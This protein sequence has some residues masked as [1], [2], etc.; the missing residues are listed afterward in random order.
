MH[1]NAAR[2]QPHCKNSLLRVL[3]GNQRPEKALDRLLPDEAHK[4]RTSQVLA[5]FQAGAQEKV[6]RILHFSLDNHNK[7][8]LQQLPES[9]VPDDARRGT[10]GADRR[11]QLH[12]SRDRSLNPIPSPPALRR[13][14]RPTDHASKRTGRVCTALNVAKTTKAVFL[15]RYQIDFRNE[16]TI[17]DALGAVTSSWPSSACPRISVCPSL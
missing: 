5:L 11:A 3:G 10:A 9:H 16:R 2:R 1:L 13:S 4:Q 17:E 14:S 12:Q 7:Q 8:A 6:M 15:E